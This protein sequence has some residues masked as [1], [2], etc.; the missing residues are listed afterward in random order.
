MKRVEEIIYIAPERREAYLQHFLN[1]SQKV[2]QIQWVHGVRNQ[3][4][5]Q[6]KD[7]ILMTFEYAGHDFYRDMA[8]MTATP[9]F[10]EYLVKKRRKDVPEDERLTTDWWAPVKRLGML[11]TESPMPPD[12]EEL[13][14]EEQYRE[15]QSGSMSIGT[16][17]Y[18][19][20]FSEDDW[21]ESVHL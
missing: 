3:C 20:S 8:E 11:L 17:S 19:I 1:P 7:Y 16:E 14:S 5:F 13:S 2:L 21:S 18:D 10:A 6:L 9:E 15:M 4:Y 12:M